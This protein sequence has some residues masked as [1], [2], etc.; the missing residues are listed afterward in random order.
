MNCTIKS[1]ELQHS[2]FPLK[3]S[4]F[5]YVSNPAT[6]SFRPSA[7]DEGSTRESNSEL[8]GDT[9][10]DVDDGTKK[11]GLRKNPVSKES[12]LGG[13]VRIQPSDVSPNEWPPRTAT[14]QCH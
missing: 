11:P 2:T 4:T 14:L 5:E 12:Q 13:S 9:A 1:L 6:P 3:L 10:I 8:A 7:Q